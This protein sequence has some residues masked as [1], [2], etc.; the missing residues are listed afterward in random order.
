MS[1]QVEQQWLAQVE[2][3]DRRKETLISFFKGC[4]SSSLQREGANS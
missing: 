3:L 1:W 2:R 4:S